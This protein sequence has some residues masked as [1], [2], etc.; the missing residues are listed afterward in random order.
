L[1]P[2]SIETVCHGLSGSDSEVHARCHERIGIDE[3]NVAKSGTNSHEE[4]ITARIFYTMKETLK[5]M[6]FKTYNRI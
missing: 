1:R 6:I 2:T 3:H 4:R 5:M